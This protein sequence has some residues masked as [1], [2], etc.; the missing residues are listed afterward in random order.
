MKRYDPGILWVAV[1]CMALPGTGSADD[2]ALVVGIGAVRSAGNDAE[3]DLPQWTLL[4]Q[5]AA[6]RD[7]EAAFRELAPDSRNEPSMYTHSPRWFGNQASAFNPAV[8]MTD[9]VTDNAYIPV[10]TLIVS[11]S[12]RLAQKVG[13]DDDY[14]V[15]LSGIGRAAGWQSHLWDRLHQPVGLAALTEALPTFTGK[16]RRIVVMRLYPEVGAAPP[17]TM[18]AADPESVRQLRGWL[19]AASRRLARGLPAASPGRILPALPVQCQALTPLRLQRIHAGLSRPDAV[20]NGLELL[21][22]GAAM[23]PV[24]QE[25]NLEVGVTEKRIYQKVRRPGPF[26]TIIEEDS[27][28]LDRI[29]W[30]IDPD[31]VVRGLTDEGIVIPAARELVEALAGQAGHSFRKTVMHNGVAYQLMF[32]QS[33][34]IMQVSYFD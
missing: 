14:L 7:A 19:E 27:D 4:A 32:D 29:E 22:L 21:D 15:F 20:R 24:A 9:G 3:V 26:F 30:R 16:G 13:A 34:K 33:I 31:V 12:R 23:E 18:V 5:P 17:V 25:V 10:A 28:V 8:L 2:V 11:E 1:L 6:R